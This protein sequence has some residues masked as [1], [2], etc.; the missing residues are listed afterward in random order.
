MNNIFAMPIGLRGTSTVWHNDTKIGICLTSNNSPLLGNFVPLNEISVMDNKG[1][2]PLSA[3]ELK[4]ITEI[5][6]DIHEIKPEQEHFMLLDA[7]ETV[8][9]GERVIHLFYL[10]HRDEF[11]VTGINY[12]IADPEK[13]S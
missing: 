10:S 2:N 11:L 5:R 3:N 4:T 1:D 13:I 9:L 12:F 7:D 8:Y 6:T